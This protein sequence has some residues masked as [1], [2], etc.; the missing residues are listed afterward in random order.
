[1]WAHTPPHSHIPGAPGAEE[2]FSCD[3]GGFCRQG[4]G[5]LGNLRLGC[6]LASATSSNP[7]ENLSGGRRLGVLKGGGAG[8]VEGGRDALSGRQ[9][10]KRE[11]QGS[12]TTLL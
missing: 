5:S 8:G 1:M 3:K 6:G 2:G 9:G 11:E 10:E 4:Q 7:P 12:G